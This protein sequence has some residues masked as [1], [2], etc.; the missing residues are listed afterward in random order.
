LFYFTNAGCILN[1]PFHKYLYSP[2]KALDFAL[3]STFIPQRTYWDKFCSLTS[4]GT[5]VW[6]GMAKIGWVSISPIRFEDYYSQAQ[7]LKLKAPS[8]NNELIQIK[9]LAIQANSKCLISFIPEVNDVLGL[10]SPSDYQGL[11][12]EKDYLF[13][14]NLEPEDYNISLQHFNDQGHY[15]YSKFLE[16]ELNRP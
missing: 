4:T 5:M 6:K 1:H 16:L 14:H 15:N 13:F 7:K 3:C 12:W 9:K 10:S 11:N 2:K 8:L